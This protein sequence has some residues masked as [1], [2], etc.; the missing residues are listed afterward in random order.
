MSPEKEGTGRTMKEDILEKRENPKSLFQKIKE[1]NY[2][3]QEIRDR[4][5]RINSNGAIETEMS[6][7]SSKFMKNIGIDIDGMSML[8]DESLYS[9]L[10]IL[11][12]LKEIENK[13]YG[14]Q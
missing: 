10:D 9:L 4:A 12:Y 6:P 1:V 13:M 5:D 8:L 7:P 3:I 14:N 2:N 11:T